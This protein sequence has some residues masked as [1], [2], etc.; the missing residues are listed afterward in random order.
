MSKLPVLN[1]CFFDLPPLA[2]RMPATLY[3]YINI[4]KYGCK[5]G[6]HQGLNYE[7]K[8]T[9]FSHVDSTPCQKTFVRK[10]LYWKDT[11]LEKQ[12]CSKIQ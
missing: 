7:K 11:L 12:S 1:H 2:Y 6:A 8:L 10:T 3:I 5:N 9:S 4:R